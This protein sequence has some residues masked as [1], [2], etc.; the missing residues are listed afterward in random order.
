VAIIRVER[1]NYGAQ[2]AYAPPAEVAY[3]NTDEIQ[4]AF[5]VEARGTG[6]HFAI[7]FRDGVNIT[8]RGDIDEVF[9]AISGGK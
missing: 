3:V 2:Y 5:P 6:P 1:L 8:C 7:R 4:Q 9:K